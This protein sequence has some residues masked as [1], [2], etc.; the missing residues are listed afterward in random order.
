MKKGC[1]GMLLGLVVVLSSVEAGAQGIVGGGVKRNSSSVKR[2][3]KQHKH[4]KVRNK[5]RIMFWGNRR[6]HW[7]R[8][9]RDEIF[10][11]REDHLIYG[12]GS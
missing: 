8:W 3:S 4:F 12:Q 11:N 10:S 6:D 7:G 5:G 1:I 2:S 9:R